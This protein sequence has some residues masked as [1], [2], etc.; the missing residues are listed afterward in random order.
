M[1][2]FGSRTQSPHILEIPLPFRIAFRNLL[3]RGS[4][5]LFLLVLLA[6]S[7]LV[8]LSIASLFD[9]LVFNLKR[10]GSVYYGGD[11]TI[12]G[13]KDRYQLII[14]DPEPLRK[15]VQETLSP[16]TVVSPRINY[17]NS[18]TTLFF[19]GESIRQRIVNG[20]DFTAEASIFQQITF[21]EGSYIPLQDRTRRRPGILVSEPVARILKARVGDDLLLYIPTVTGQ[22]NTAVVV[23]E[24]IF[25]DSS[26]FG[27]YT[28]YM[29]IEALRTLIRFPAGQCTDLAVYLPD[30]RSVEEAALRLQK[31][32]ESRFPLTPLFLKQQD[33]WNYRDRTEWTGMRYALTTLDANLGQVNDLLDAVRFIAYVLLGILGSIVFFGVTNSYRLTVFE[34]RKEIGTLRALGMPKGTVTVIFLLEGV[35][36]TAFSLAAGAAGAMVFLFGLSKVNF[37]FLVGF[38]I[39]LRGGYLQ[40][41]TSANAL[42][43]TLLLSL[44][45]VLLA[46]LKPTL[47]AASIPPMEAMQEGR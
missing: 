32:L 13:L 21:I 42:L 35:F 34:R 44:S 28:A 37:S 20:V 31:A 14:E 27:Y 1:F 29:D 5:F 46:L 7:S 8:I 23:L 4:R 17:R 22:I 19:A 12:R 36:L 39:F 10:K 25:R 40:V 41:S 2:P 30:S 11:I 43:L 18:S 3:R 24:G 26:L 33:L 47:M 6:F 45:A 16:E 9:T 15:G 38:D